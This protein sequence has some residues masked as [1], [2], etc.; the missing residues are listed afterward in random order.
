MLLSIAP[1]S[2]YF[3]LN[4]DESQAKSCVNGG[5][6]RYKYGAD[7]RVDTNYQRTDNWV[8]LTFIQLPQTSKI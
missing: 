2:I 7:W 1:L 4:V 8:M 6:Y 3:S 5:T